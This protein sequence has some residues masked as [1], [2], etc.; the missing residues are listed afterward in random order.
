MLQLAKGLVVAGMIE[1]M[2]GF[3]ETLFSQLL[4]YKFSSFLGSCVAIT[5]TK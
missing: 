5:N 1:E 4:K 2:P 3:G